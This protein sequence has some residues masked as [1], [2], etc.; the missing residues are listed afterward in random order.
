[1]ESQPFE[2][3]SGLA[4][5]L[6]DEGMSQVE[7]YRLYHAACAKHR[8]DPDDVIYDAIVDTMDF[9]VGWCQPGHRLF[10]S[11]LREGDVT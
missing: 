8:G 9:I 10:A 3:L 6:R 2:A 7:L 5:T 1:M 11:D 4:K